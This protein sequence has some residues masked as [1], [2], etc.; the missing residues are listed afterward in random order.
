MQRIPLLSIALVV[1]MAGPAL[2]AAANTS[3]ADTTTPPTPQLHHA[4][5]IHRRVHTARAKPHHVAHHVTHHVTQHVQLG[6][7]S[8]Y[9]SWHAGRRTADGERF[10]PTALTAAH[11]TLPMNTKVLVKNLR[12]GRTVTVRIND[13]LPAGSPR[14]IDLTRRAAADLGMERRGVAPVM[15]EALNRDER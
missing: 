13:R 5:H 11:Q 14:V 7:A 1:A 8:W 2:P 12:N 10:D 6:Q 9:G 4:R 3:A 15:V